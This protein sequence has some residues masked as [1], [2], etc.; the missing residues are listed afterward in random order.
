ML[1]NG[2][3]YGQW[4]DGTQKAAA[5]A[6]LRPTPID[7]SLSN[8]DVPY[9]GQY[10]LPPTPG[11]LAKEPSRNPAFNLSDGILFLNNGA[12]PAVDRSVAKHWFLANQRQSLL[13]EMHVHQ[14]WPPSRPPVATWVVF[15]RQATH[16]TGD[17]YFGLTEAAL[18]DGVG[19][20][21]GAD[22][23][24]NLRVGK[25]PGKLGTD[26][27]KIN[28]VLEVEWQPVAFPATTPHPEGDADGRR[29][30][31]IVSVNLWK[32][33]GYISA[34]PHWTPEAPGPALWKM[35]LNLSGW[36]SARLW[37]SMRS[38]FDEVEL[39]QLL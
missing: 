26:A 21:I 35:R 33:C 15:A 5:E 3:K 14:A 4:Y 19:R 16:A 39:L 11:E 36:A 17:I 27:K 9:Y 2:V 32:H 31:M 22:V 18:P 13:S 10:Q 37:V 38:R 28:D 12:V 24:G 1:D 20:C 6:A 30:K 34:H 29:C 25:D 23:A 7:P 8:Y